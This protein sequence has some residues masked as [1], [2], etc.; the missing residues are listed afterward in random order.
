MKT[1][2]LT[3]FAIA[4]LSNPSY[5]QRRTV[6]R[7][8]AAS[9]GAVAYVHENMFKKGARE[10]KTL[11]P[12]VPNETLTCDAGVIS[13]VLPKIKIEFAGKG[14]TED[15][16]TDA[17]VDGWKI[18]RLTSPLQPDRCMHRDSY[19]QLTFTLGKLV[20]TTTPDRASVEVAEF[21]GETTTR[22]WFEPQTYQVKYSKEGYE[23]V[24][25]ACVVLEGKSNECHADLK[26]LN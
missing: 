21:R 24:E 11:R 10:I 22:R 16:A 7:K 18:V 20:F 19:H 9:P 25:L 1:L 6:A 15:D 26:K 8:P 4:V 14:F 3:L 23:S 13:S 17:A 5:G 12:A 2:I